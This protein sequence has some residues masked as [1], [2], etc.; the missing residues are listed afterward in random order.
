[1]L[2]AMSSGKLIAT[3]LQA[4]FALAALAPSAFPQTHPKPP[5]SVQLYVFDNGVINGMDPAA[6][7]LKKEEVATLDMV[8][9]SY[10]IVHPKGILMWD[11][12]AIPDAEFK[13][14]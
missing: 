5:K 8:L 14:G 7:H 3:T 13:A 1:M 9:S 10:L 2:V 11:S 12:G 4:V 6:F